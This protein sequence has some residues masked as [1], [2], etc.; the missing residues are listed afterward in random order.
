MQHSNPSPLELD[1]EEDG[2]K[3][4]LVF[5]DKNRKQQDRRFQ[6]CLDEHHVKRSPL[7]SFL[8]NSDNSIPSREVQLARIV[9]T[10]KP[11][12]AECDLLGLRRAWVECRTKVSE[13]NQS[14]PS[15]ITPNELSNFIQERVSSLPY[16]RMFCIIIDDL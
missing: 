2:K 9:L 3:W 15:W 7:E 4:N 10:S 11:P 16:L 8:Q 1:D 14:P 6:K 13:Q 12:S 5:Y